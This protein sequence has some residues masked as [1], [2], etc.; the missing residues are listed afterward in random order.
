MTIRDIA[1]ESGYAISTVSRALNNH[2]DVS[3]ETKQR[4]AE[5]VARTGFVP[6]T[7]ARQ[8]KRQQAKSIAFIV[9]STSNLF[10]ADVLVE[11]QRHVSEAGYDGVV[12]YLDENADELAVAEQVCRE[13]RPKGIV[14]LGGNI[15]AFRE[16][17][18]AIRVP[19]VL[20][21]SV[22][23]LLQ[24]DNLSMVGVDD[25]TAAALAAGHL[26]GLGHR[27]IAMLGGCDTSYISRQRRAGCERALAALGVPFDPDL[28]G[29]AD[30]TFDAAYEATQ[31]LL[32]QKKPF[33]ALLAMSDVMAVAAVRALT[34]AG[35]AVPREV[36]V[37]GFD[38]T[39]M[40]RY[41]TPR[42]T[43]VAQPAAEIA[44][45]SISLLLDCIE[46]NSPAR[47][48][49]LEASLLEGESTCAP[50]ETR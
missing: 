1:R 15:D 49:V 9:K 26:A 32:R 48:L 22:S 38:G 35:L 4:I 12:Q 45:A 34:D 18:S 20:A 39:P 46:K 27:Q 31:R 7:N 40:A 30:F 3:E 23:S 24:F 25:K 5:I 13:A 6:N 36:S 47:T 29:E 17:F 14:F 33:T 11:L 41:S 16:R 37:T 44:Q 10:F 42:L 8:L 19:C 28:Y 43:T 2:P 50:C 21:T